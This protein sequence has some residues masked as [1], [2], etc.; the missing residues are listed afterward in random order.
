[1]KEQLFKL[2]NKEE[3]VEIYTDLGDV[4]TCAVAKVLNLSDE[5]V[6]LANV[7][8]TG[9]YDGFSLI[10]TEKIYQI[11]LDTLYLRKIDK[12]YKAKKQSHIKVD[13]NNEN[14]MMGIIEFAKRN[15]FVVLIELY[16]SATVQGLIK[17]EENGV[18]IVT[19]LTQFGKRDGESL[20]KIEDITTIHI[21]DEDRNCLKILD[22]EKT[23]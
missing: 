22:F 20:I 12:L 18:L 21:D 3:L 4:D 23:K 11:S 13:I 8:P 6:I 19:N 7:S 10:Q 15:N 17:S 5:Y 16:E 14:L 1:M 2:T 9:M